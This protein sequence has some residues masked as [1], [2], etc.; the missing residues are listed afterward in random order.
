MSVTVRTL[1]PGEVQA[2][3]ADLARLRIAVFRE[4]PY[5]YD[6]D[7]TYES[8]YLT[9]FAAA[10]D[11]V[12]A[13]AFDGDRIV[14][15]ATAS[16]MAAQDA[17]IRDP[18][19]THGFDIAR[20]FY[21]GESVLLPQWRGQGIGHGF[22]DAR[23]TGARRAGAQVATFCAVIRADDHPLRPDGARSHA[24][25]WTKRGYAPVPGLA[26]TMHWRDVGEA[27]ESAKRLQ[28]WSRAL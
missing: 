19:A 18:V 23:E 17:A 20:T 21:F 2:R 10:P 7:N 22:F 24:A 3:L 26:C 1:D 16:P 12:L 14:G 5:L 28:F 9:A 6:G 4:W 25:F 15:M 8:A 13:A 11:A 27:G